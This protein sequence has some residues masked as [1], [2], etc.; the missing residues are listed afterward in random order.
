MAV[1]SKLNKYVRDRNT[2]EFRVARICIFSY[3]TPHNFGIIWKGLLL[4][5]CTCCMTTWYFCGHLIDFKA[6]WVH[7]VVICFIFPILMHCIKK[8]LVTLLT[9]RDEESPLLNTWAHKSIHLVCVGSRLR[10]FRN[11]YQK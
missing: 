9:I 7:F 2:D 4:K 10:S 11:A 8:N 3:Q 6:I 1:F 5:L